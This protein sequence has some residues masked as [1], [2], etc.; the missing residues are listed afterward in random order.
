MDFKLFGGI[1]MIIKIIIYSTILLFIVL[2]FFITC[3]F[4]S[5]SRLRSYYDRKIDD[6]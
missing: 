2:S 6:N 4:M 3:I 1:I 5:K